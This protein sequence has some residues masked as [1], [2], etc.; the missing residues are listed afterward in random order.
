[1]SLLHRPARRLPA[2]VL[3]AALSLAG[4]GAVL[5]GSAGVARGESLWSGSGGGL[6]AP[7]LFADTK[8]RQVGDLVTIIISERA[9]ASQS[10]STEA[11]QSSDVRLR[12][13]GI[14]DG[15]LPLFE[16]GES[17]SDQASGRIRR[18]GSLQ[19]RV[20]TRVVELLPN[21]VLRVEGRQ[22]ILVNGERQEIVIT[23]LVR[24]R[25]IS[26]DNTVLSTYVADASISF[27]GEGPLGD[28]QRPGLLSRLLNWLF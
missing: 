7:S 5:L 25:D 2:L 26:A 18:A 23:G 22:T 3:R 19:A 17:D 1:M 14:L 21:G 11:G 6:G 9:Q 8:A 15:F 27:V 20:T 13:G 12:P 4:A 28:K 16:F 10:A 24:S